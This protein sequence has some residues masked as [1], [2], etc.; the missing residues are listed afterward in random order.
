MAPP[1][2]DAYGY[3]FRV[4]ALLI[5]P[6]ARRGYIDSTTLDATA[7]LKF[8][9][10]L[11]GLAP[12]SERSAR[13]N[14]LLGAFDFTQPPRRPALVGSERG[15]AAQAAPP[16]AAIDLCYSAALL[17]GGMIIAAA[18]MAAG[19]AGAPTDKEQAL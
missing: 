10:D 11:H 13:A 19:R 4:P 5:S 2:V 18:T 17:L 8:I 1:Q 14:S 7:V 6:Y 12:L 3:G 16:R 9:E 15:V